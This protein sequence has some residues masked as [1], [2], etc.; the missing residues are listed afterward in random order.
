M[1]PGL[2]RLCTHPIITGSGPT[3]ETIGTFG[4]ALCAAWIDEPPLVTMILAPCETNSLAR[5]ERRSA[6]PSATRYSTRILLPSAYPKATK[7]DRNASVIGR[8]AVSEAKLSQPI[9]GIVRCWACARLN[10][11]AAAPPIK[12]MKSRRFT[13]SPIKRV[14][15]HEACR[16]RNAHATCT[17]HSITSSARASS[18]GGI[19]SASVF[20]VLRLMMS[21]RIRDLLHRVDF[22]VSH[23]SAPGRDSHPLVHTPWDNSFRS[24]PI[25]HLLQIVELDILWVSCVEQPDQ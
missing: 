11:A 9:V 19:M 16:E 4:A 24:L 22:Q 15:P 23:H 5:A 2:A 7:P 3:H 14:C 17:D 25:L 18:V 8:T 12:V 21:S 10:D 20:A 1:P 13:L 6:C